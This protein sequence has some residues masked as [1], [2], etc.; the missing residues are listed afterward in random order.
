MVLTSTITINSSNKTPELINV[1]ENVRQA[2]A[3]SGVKNGQVTIFSQHTTAAV[4]LQENEP[5]IHKDI[6]KFLTSLLP[7][8]GDYQHSVAPDHM[9]DR[10]PNGHSHLQHF[11]LGG[12]SQVIPFADGELMLGTFQSIFLVEL[13]RARSRKIVVQIIGE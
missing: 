5:G 12:S 7:V 9:K 11:L 1:T 2:V 4:I 13:D 6:H 3:S 8:D 10:M